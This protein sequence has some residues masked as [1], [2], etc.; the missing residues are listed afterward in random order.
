MILEKMKSYIKE[1]NFP[2]A[3][4][5]YFLHIFKLHLTNKFIL[6]IP[7]TINEKCSRNSHEPDID[8]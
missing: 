2:I 8:H 5:S 3:N 4:D 6:N 1:V 7:F